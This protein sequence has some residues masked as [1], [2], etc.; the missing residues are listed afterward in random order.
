M[1]KRRVGELFA[2]LVGN[3]SGAASSAA[4]EE[5]EEEVEEE[6][7]DNRRWLGFGAQQTLAD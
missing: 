5:N 2:G 6:E 3:K 7:E 1:M 4:D